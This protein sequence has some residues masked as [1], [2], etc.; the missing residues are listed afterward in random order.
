MSTL[1]CPSRSST[2]PAA[3]SQVVLVTQRAA[4]ERD[5]SDALH[6]DS[7]SIVAIR[8]VREIGTL[9]ASPDVLILDADLAEA[10]SMQN[11]LR[12]RRRWPTI[13]I[14]ALNV[15]SES[16]A[17]DLLS[18]GVDDAIEVRCPWYYTS[19]RLGAVT[20]RAR[21]ANAQLRRRIGDVVYDRESRRV[22]CR[23]EE[24]DFAPR[25][26]AVLDC[27]WWRAGEVVGHDTL[28]DFVWARTMDVRGNNRVEV[29]ISYLRRKLR[30]SNEVSIQTLRG[31]GYR[32]I[33]CASS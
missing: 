23:G 17:A 10:T 16:A 19:A 15:A 13:G 2:E 29:Y 25:E 33:R 4:L 22:W 11:I 1:V 14:V 28:H 24:V 7:T 12:I 20:R 18:L 9:D 3:V 30:H 6:D 21:T 31:A 5:L 27:L 8:S 32:L 26:L